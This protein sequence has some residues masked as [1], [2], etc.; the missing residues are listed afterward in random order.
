MSSNPPNQPPMP[1]G[2]PYVPTTWPLGGTNVKHVDIPITAVF[3][4]LFIIGAVIHMTIFQLNQRKHHKF[5]FSALLFGFCM[6]RITTCVV[7]IASLCFPMNIKLAIAAQVFVAAGVVIIF[8]VNLVF[9]QRMIRASHPHLGW[10]TAFS[11]VFKFFYA[12]IILTIIMLIVVVVQSFYTLS[13]NT[14][15]IDRAIQLYGATVFAFISFLPIPMVAASLLTPRKQGLDKFGAGRWRVKP[16]ILLTG[17][18]LVSFGATYR[19]G[20]TWVTPVPRSQPLPWYFHKAAFYVVNFTVEILT[21]YLY[22]FTRVDKRFYVIDGAHKRRSYSTLNL[23]EIHRDDN[24]NETDEEKAIRRQSVA[25][26][27]AQS[28]ETFHDRLTLV[29]NRDSDAGS[30][31]GW[32]R[33]KSVETLPNNRDSSRSVYNRDRDSRSNYTRDSRSI[34]RSDSAEP[35]PVDS[36]PAHVHFPMPIMP[37]AYAEYR[38]SGD[39]KS[40][41][42]APRAKNR[43]SSESH[44]SR[45]AAAT[46]VNGY[47]RSAAATPV[48]SN[49]QSA[50]ATPPVDAYVEAEHSPMMTTTRSAEA[51]WPLR[52]PNSRESHE[53]A[54][55]A[56]PVDTYT[57]AGISVGV[58]EGSTQVTPADAYTGAEHFPMTS[59][60]TVAPTRAP[61]ERTP[62]DAYTGAG[63]SPMTSPTTSVTSTNAPPPP[64]TEEHMSAEHTTAPV[65]ST[66][67]RRRTLEPPPNGAT[68]RVTL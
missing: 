10:T 39:A 20:T 54:I 26:A 24:P 38:R 47:S 42:I 30:R 65:T 41:E 8:I 56:T 4:G 60:M 14:R 37:A 58:Y 45:S 12:W 19:A 36:Y 43:D 40:L 33:Y 15:R 29:N 52:D 49:S 1:K 61:T 13:T 34:F 44:Y 11:V 62:A 2:P 68:S 59:T 57:G 27:A 6:A 63:Q 17:A 23:H 46:P 9:S 51:T 16:L 18:I 35:T 7:R 53:G 48:G 64:L 66:A 3:L 25:A 22:A 50:V 28:A 31:T 32:G 21:V 67:E 5:L 55:E